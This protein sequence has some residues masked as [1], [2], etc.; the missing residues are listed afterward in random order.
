M[1][2]ILKRKKKIVALFLALVAIM[3]IGFGL[4][5]N[6]IIVLAA[7]LAVVVF[8]FIN[9]YILRKIRK[10]LE[11]FGVYSEIRNVDYLI[12]GNPLQVADYVPVGSSYVEV[13][14]PNRSYDSTWQLLRHTH[15][16]LKDGGTVLMAVDRNRKGFSVFDIPFLHPITIK[17][18]HIERLKKMS[19]FPIIFALSA[20]IRLAFG[21]GYSSYNVSQNIPDKLK[22]F[23]DA[24]NYKLIFL[25]KI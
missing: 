20:S 1:S 24:R 9:E 3:L 17:K 10:E 22:E 6:A 16:I 14:A 4:H 12:L 15:S 11:P 7:C 2:R 8:F 21:R 25:E 18:Y 5:M 13:C 23:C 19:H